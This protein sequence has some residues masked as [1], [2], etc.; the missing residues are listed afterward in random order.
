MQCTCLY[1]VLFKLIYYISKQYTA[2]ITIF[3][4]QIFL[5]I[6]MP[7]LYQYTN[8]NIILLVHANIHTY[9]NI[10]YYYIKI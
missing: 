1:L 6:L 9:N 4:M 2:I 3:I 7:I 8:I 5:Y 10:F